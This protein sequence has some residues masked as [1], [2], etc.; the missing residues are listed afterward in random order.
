[1]R[2]N[3]GIGVEVLSPSNL[4]SSPDMPPAERFA[5]YLIVHA[6]LVVQQVD[7]WNEECVDGCIRY[8]LG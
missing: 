7:P 4:F 1:M 2:G 8:L 5:P 6:V 3:P